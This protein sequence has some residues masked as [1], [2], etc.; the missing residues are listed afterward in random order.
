M[1]NTI[2]KPEWTKDQKKVYEYLKKEVHAKGYNQAIQDLIVDHDSNLVS[3]KQL[4]V[5]NTF[6]YMDDKEWFTVADKLKEVE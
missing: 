1:K 3:K 6:V 5:Y 2:K 4:D